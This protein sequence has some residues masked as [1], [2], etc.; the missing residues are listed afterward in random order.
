[1]LDLLRE[2]RDRVLDKIHRFKLP[3]LEELKLLRRVNRLDTELRKA[4]ADAK[5]AGVDGPL[6]LAFDPAEFGGDGRAVL[7]FGHDPYDAD[8]VSVHVPGVGTT[9]NSRFFFGFYTSCALNHLVSTR[10]ENRT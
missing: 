8:S 3:S 2:R 7:S 6:L 4:S 10:Q 9:V 5:R 1:M